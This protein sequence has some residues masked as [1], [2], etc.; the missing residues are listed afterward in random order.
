MCGRWVGQARC[1]CH[2]P[3]QSTIA[4]RGLEHRE[5]KGEG[6]EHLNKEI[7]CIECEGRVPQ[8]IGRHEALGQKGAAEAADGLLGL[9]VGSYRMLVVLGVG[10]G[11]CVMWGT[12]FT[13]AMT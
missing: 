1:R 8:Q 10:A 13:C 6:E 5:D 9:W 2:H 3:Y 11:V 7:P 12:H 4:H